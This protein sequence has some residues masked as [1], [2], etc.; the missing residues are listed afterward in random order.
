MPKRGTVLHTG[1][2]LLEAVQRRFRLHDGLPECRM[3]LLIPGKQSVK[4]LLADA[5]YGVGF[6]QLFDD[7]VKFLTSPPVLV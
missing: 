6:V 2:V 7:G 5:P 1:S 3:L 4:S